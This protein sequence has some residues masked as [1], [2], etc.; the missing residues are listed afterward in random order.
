[1]KKRSTKLLSLMTAVALLS[2]IFSMLPQG[3]L[4][5]VAA[6]SENGV[7]FD[8][9]TGVLELRGRFTKD[10]VIFYRHNEK[11][12]N[13]VAR[14]GCVLPADCSRMF[15]QAESESGTYEWVNVDTLDLRNADA[16]EATDISYMFDRTNGIKHVN[17]AGL[18]F[19]NVTAS[20][21][22]FWGHETLETVD[23]TNV[24]MPKAESFGL[25][26]IT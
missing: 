8:E 20:R 26:F 10:Q 23:L 15:G 18:D 5:A 7:F 12:R 11:V 2:A 4:S 1:M 25:M 16:S 13:I 24:K 17:M 6:S 22:M 9:N 19:A 3:V 21:S 14:E